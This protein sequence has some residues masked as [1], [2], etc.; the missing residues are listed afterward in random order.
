MNVSVLFSVQVSAERRARTAIQEE[1]DPEDHVESPAAVARLALQ[2]N[3]VTPVLK[4]SRDPRARRV[5]VDRL[6]L[7]VRQDPRAPLGHKDR[8]G[9]QALMEITAHRVHLENT[10]S[11]E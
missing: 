1:K 8:K 3:S 6:V 5:T 2:E 9:Q 4:G 10:A 7:R 11:A